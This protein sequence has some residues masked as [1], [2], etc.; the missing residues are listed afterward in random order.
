MREIIAACAAVKGGQGFGDW[1]GV[2][3]QMC[4]LSMWAGGLEAEAGR[5]CAAAVCK[6][7]SSDALH[8]LQCGACA[9]R[10]RQGEALQ[11]RKGQV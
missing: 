2:L 7:Q 1:C 8:P 11:V 10:S 5:R 3:P 4:G 9:A 6:D